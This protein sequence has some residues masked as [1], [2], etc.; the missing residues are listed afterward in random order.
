MEKLACWQ[1]QSGDYRNPLLICSIEVF[2]YLT[3]QWHLIEPVIIDTGYDGD[4][5]FADNY[6]SSLGFPQF[7]IPT[8]SFDIAETIDHSDIILK[9]SITEVKWGGEQFEIRVECIPENQET[10]LGRGLFLKFSSC[11]NQK[12]QEFCLVD[13]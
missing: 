3:F 4:L 12:K 11:F 2:S 8:S 7:E 1:L 13:K 9:A 10:I 5:L 6:Y